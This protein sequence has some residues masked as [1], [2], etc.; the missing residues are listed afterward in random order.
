MLLDSS[1]MPSVKLHHLRY[2][3]AIAREKSLHG[4]ARSLGLAQPGLTRGLKELEEEVGSSLVERH[5]QGVSLTECGKRFLVRATSVLEELRRAQEDA[6]QSQ[7]KLTGHLTLG[8]SPV[9]QVVL[10]PHM[11]SGFICANPDVRLQIIEGYFPSIRSR[12]DDGSMDFYVGPCPESAGREFQ[13]TR[14][15]KSERCVVARRGHRLAGCTSLKDL[16]GCD[17]QICGIRKNLDDEIAEVFVP[18]GL[19]TPNHIT[20]ISSLFTSLVLLYST[21]LLLVVPKFCMSSP[22]FK[23]FVMIP[24]QESIGGPDIVQIHRTGMP[25]SLIAERFSSALE[26]VVQ[27][28]I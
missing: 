19:P 4:A 22:L 16:V 25:L 3:I 9:A 24:L 10:L 5:S 2:F 13:M 27:Q 17:W 7:G 1:D 15:W 6:T 18:H 23:E 26:H 12:L 28:V 11:F 14:L 8:L 20:I 21:D